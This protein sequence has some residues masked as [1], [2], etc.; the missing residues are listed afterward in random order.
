MIK[1]ILKQVTTGAI[2]IFLK[3]VLFI[4]KPFYRFYTSLL[5]DIFRYAIWGNRLQSLGKDT[6]IYPYVVIHSPEYVKVGSN[7][8]IAEFV[9]IW[10]GGA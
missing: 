2:N 7:V 8:S 3:I 6:K 5:I 1:K 4:S 10:G 9:H